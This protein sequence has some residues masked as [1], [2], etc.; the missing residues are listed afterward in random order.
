MTQ[1]THS[2]SASILGLLPFAP[3]PSVSPICA[4]DK[5]IEVVVG[6]ALD[7]Q[8]D[9]FLSVELPQVYADE[10]RG[11]VAGAAAD[12]K[13]TA[14]GKEVNRITVLAN[15]PGDLKDFVLVLIA[16][17]K[18]RHPH[19]PKVV[20]RL[21]DLLSRETGGGPPHGHCSMFGAW[22]SRTEGGN[23][24]SGRNLDWESDTG[25]N[26]Y[27]LVTVFH[28]PDAIAHA[29]IGFAGVYGALT[30]MSAKGLTVHE[31]NLEENEITFAGFPWL[32]RLRYV[33]EMASNASEAK[34]LWEH[35]NNTVGE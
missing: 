21:L 20:A 10:I 31:A 7:W 18:E 34:A 32:L 13:S 8:W 6:L 27:K 33:M 23:L 4:Q 22:G 29:T 14:A 30:G 11:I 28:P 12:G 19:E 17:W 9:S 24:F 26:K 2:P 25:I 5:A 15:A 16:E 35:T 3:R 1:P